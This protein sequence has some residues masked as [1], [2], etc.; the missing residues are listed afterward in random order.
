M[1]GRAHSRRKQKARALC[2][3]TGGQPASGTPGWARVP[4]AEETLLLF[5]CK[6]GSGFVSFFL[7]SLF[8]PPSPEDLLHTRPVA[9]VDLVDGILNLKFC[10]SVQYVY[11]AVVLCF[12]RVEPAGCYALCDAPRPVGTG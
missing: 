10:F 11:L 6:I 4:V 12:N 1:P 9:S 8:V 3:L 7:I 2:S 5:C